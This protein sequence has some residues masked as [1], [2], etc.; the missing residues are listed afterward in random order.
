MKKPISI[1]SNSM[2][3]LKWDLKMKLSIFLFLLSIF[4]IHATS[5][6]QKTRITVNMSNV[7]LGEVLD[8][9]ETNSEFKFFV[10]TRK[11]NINRK[12]SI[13]VRKEKISNI[14]KDL[15]RGTD[16]I[17]EVYNKQILLKKDKGEQVSL[18]KSDSIGGNFKSV[19]L[20]ISGIITDSKGIPLPG[21]NVIEKGTTNGVTA[22]F[23]G[24]FCCWVWNPKEDEFDWSCIEYQK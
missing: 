19:Q 4:Q 17:Y 2:Y 21:A 7:N 24:Q 10:D 22:D 3:L 9:I 13:N 23:E 16:V 8:R 15:F 11:I 14:L 5:Y 6:S 12:V 18:P 20:S 1:G